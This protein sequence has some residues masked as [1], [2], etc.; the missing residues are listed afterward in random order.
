[1]ETINTDYKQRTWTIYAKLSKM[2]KPSS[3]P[4]KK[5]ILDFLEGF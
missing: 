2:N 3:G 5:G 4:L 1:M